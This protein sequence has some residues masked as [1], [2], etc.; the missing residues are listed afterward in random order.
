MPPIL[1]F[2]IETIPD[3][4]GL[5]LLRGLGDDLSDA[6]VVEMAQRLLRQEK[7]SDFM[8]HH[9]HKIVTISC[10]LRRQTDN[11]PLIIFSLPTTGDDEA[12]TIRQFFRAIEKYQP[13]LVSWNGGGFDL[14]VLHYR[15]MKHGITAATYWQVGDKWENYRSR[16]GKRHTDLMDKLGIY[17][18]R[19]WAP[20]DEFAKLC[21]LPG[22]I[23]VGG[24]GV[25]RAWQ[26]GK[27]EDI[28]RY[29]ENDALLTY[30]LYWRFQQFRGERGADAEWALARRYLR[31]HP[32]THWRD[33]VSAWDNGG[34]TPPTADNTP[35]TAK[36]SPPN[37]LSLL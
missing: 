14:P 27:R 11:D 17:Q 5:R 12:D 6:D 16:Y 35:A 21:G 2:D 22:K 23:G 4:Q 9:L 37:G 25:W 28:R 36:N 24:D 7:N 3:A 34:E 29:C 10:V 15:A 1:A 31:E 20:L 8:P 32:E 18:P 33:F 30:L 26:D 13:I 19:A